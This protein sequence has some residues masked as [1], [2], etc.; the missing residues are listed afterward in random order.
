MPKLLLLITLAALLGS[1]CETRDCLRSHKE[2]RW[3]PPVTTY[4]YIGQKGAMR[5]VPLTIPGR[6][7]TVDV[8]DEYVSSTNP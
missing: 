5:F 1:G 7:V 3:K 6:Y 2:Q 4:P 8:C